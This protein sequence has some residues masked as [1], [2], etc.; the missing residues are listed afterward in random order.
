MDENIIAVIGILIPIVAIL[1]MAGAFWAY[2]AYL[3]RGKKEVQLTLRAMIE[4]GQQ[5][6]P[7]LLESLSIDSR[8]R[9]EKDLRRGVRE[10]GIGVALVAI[11]IFLRMS[12]DGESF[13]PILAAAAIFI[14]MGSVY[15]GLY[16]FAPNR[17]KERT[18]DLD[19]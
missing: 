6:S 5:I 13:Y 2:L 8:D 19:I 15:L 12:G 10:V 17:G 16:K 11:A 1:S 4:S 18:N 7:E 9:R 3:Q 14:T